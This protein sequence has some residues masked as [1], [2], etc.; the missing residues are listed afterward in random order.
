MKLLLC[1]LLLAS[2]CALSSRSVSSGTF[3]VTQSPDV[4]VTEGETVN[5]TCC[6]PLEFGRF[7][8]NWMK[9]DTHVGSF[10]LKNLSQGSLQ[11]ETSKCS[12]LTLINVTREHS[13]TY[14]CRV[15][16]EIPVLNTRN[17]NGTVL[18]VVDNTE[19]NSTRGQDIPFMERSVIICLAVVT[20]LLLITLLCFCCLRRRQARVIYEAPHID[21]EDVEMDKHSTSSSTGSSQWC[22]VPVYESFDYFERVEN[23][24]SE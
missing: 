2:H 24:E 18:T 1:S 22:Q 23:K 21:S 5:I 11:K 19:V 20:P 6:W 16:L 17:G 10:N 15:T 7:R 12:N 13:G 8:V 9:H 4:S 3:D 14:I